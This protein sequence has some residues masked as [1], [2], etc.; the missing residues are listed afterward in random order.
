MDIKPDVAT[1]AVNRV[2]G[3]VT[4]LRLTVQE[5]REPDE[6]ERLGIRIVSKEVIV[7]DKKT[8]V[9]EVIHV[10]PITTPIPSGKPRPATPER[11]NATIQQYIDA[12]VWDGPKTMWK[13]PA[14][15]P[16]GNYKWEIVPNDYLN[17]TT[18]K[19]FRN[20]WVHDHG[21]GQQK[22][23]HDMPKAREIHRVYLRKARF[24]E[25]CRLDNEYVIAEDAGDL[26]AKKVI[27]A[28]RQ[29][30]RDVTEDTRIEAAQTIEELKSLKLVDLIPETQGVNYMTEKMRVSPSIINVPNKLKT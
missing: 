22:P 10:E 17:E 18:D 2:D 3:G 21:K 29:K 24:V 8:T 19:T 25:F 4:I 30:F 9:Y 5:Y 27:G 15:H 6:R 7:N 11:V 16:N 12:G 20:A 23:V 14:T 28:L 26:E 1:V 13:V